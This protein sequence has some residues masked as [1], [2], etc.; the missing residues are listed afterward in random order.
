MPS[1]EYLIF[2]NINKREVPTRRK[3]TYANAICDRL[4][5]DDPE[6]RWRSVGDN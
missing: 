1:T 6:V 4:T 2:F 5:K 3:A